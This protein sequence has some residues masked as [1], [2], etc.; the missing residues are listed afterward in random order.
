M[1]RGCS[2]LREA[3]GGVR[4]TFIDPHGDQ[5]AADSADPTVNMGLSELACA[6]LLNRMS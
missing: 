3:A 4:L 1:R 5:C 2:R 6:L